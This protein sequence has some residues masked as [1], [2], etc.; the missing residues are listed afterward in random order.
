[1]C[2][3][4][5]TGD[6]LTKENGDLRYYR[7]VLDNSRYQVVQDEALERKLAEKLTTITNQ[8]RKE[9]G[10]KK[11]SREKSQQKAMNHRRRDQVI[12]HITEQGH[13]RV[14]PSHCMHRAGNGH[15]TLG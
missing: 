6:V 9:T 13:V 15:S 14:R 3:P 2:G 5:M 11:T 1:M 12:Q 7:W 10:V 4:Q 8:V